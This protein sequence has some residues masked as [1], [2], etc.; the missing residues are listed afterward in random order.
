M[1]NATGVVF[2]RNPNQTHHTFRYTDALGL[3]RSN[4]MDA[5]RRDLQPHLPLPVPPPNDAP[6]IG[7]VTVDGMELR[8]HAY[9]MEE[10][11]VNVGRITGP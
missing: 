8:Y 11:L 1:N 9:P 2:G 10:G 5:I 7:T 3:D 6:F 4:V